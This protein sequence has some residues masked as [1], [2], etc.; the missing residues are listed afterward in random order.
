VFFAFYVLMAI[1]LV[2]ASILRVVLSLR[3]G[4]ALDVLP[5]ITGGLGLVA[6][7]VL[8]PRVLRRIRASRRPAP[9]TLT[10]QL[11]RHLGRTTE[12]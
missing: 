4:V 10:E 11:E 12:R 1:W 9:A 5:A 6:L 2:F 8:V 7:L 3:S